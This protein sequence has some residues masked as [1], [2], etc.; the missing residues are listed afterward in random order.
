MG[1][2]EETEIIKS[3]ASGSK[4]RLPCA[5]AAVLEKVSHPWADG[6]A[7]RSPPLSLMWQRLG[8]PR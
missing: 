3:I 8:S 1:C 7:V 4:S 2:V 5:A 6:R